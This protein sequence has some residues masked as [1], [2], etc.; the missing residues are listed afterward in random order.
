[1]RSGNR[2]VA[3]D[4]QGKGGPSAFFAAALD[5]LHGKGMKAQLI[6]PV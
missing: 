1:M 5:Q 2:S 4:L 6:R 3:T